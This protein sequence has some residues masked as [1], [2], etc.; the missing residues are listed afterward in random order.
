MALLYALDSQFST[1]FLSHNHMIMSLTPSIRQ[2]IFTSMI[3]TKQSLNKFLPIS[4]WSYGL[5][6]IVSR[7]NIGR[8]TTVLCLSVLYKWTSQLSEFYKSMSVLSQIVGFVQVWTFRCRKFTNICR[9]CT[10]EQPH[11]GYIFGL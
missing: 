6:T 7:L 11:N 3:M 5:I 1:L 9:F 2:Q 8:L 4:I 10:N